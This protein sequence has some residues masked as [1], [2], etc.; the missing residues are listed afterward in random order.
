MQYLGFLYYKGFIH[1]WE[2]STAHTINNYKA[3]IIV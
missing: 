1:V 3:S 2:N